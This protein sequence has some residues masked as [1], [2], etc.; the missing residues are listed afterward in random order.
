MINL[1]Y[2]HFDQVQV[3]S[4]NQRENDININNL[5]QRVSTIYFSSDQNHQILSPLLMLGRIPKNRNRNN[6]QLRM[7]QRKYLE[8][9][10][11][12]SMVHYPRFC[13]S[14]ERFVDLVELC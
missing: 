9:L 2:L 5:L 6:F 4:F 14:V 1:K 12:H 3:S 8:S 13:V 11:I 7:I 10:H